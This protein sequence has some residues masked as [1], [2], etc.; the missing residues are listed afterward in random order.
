VVPAAAFALYVPRP[1]ANELNVLIASGVGAANIREIQ[2]P[3]GERISGWAFAH[4][5]VVLN[6]DAALE[7]GPVVKTFSTPLRYAL[8]VPIADG[9]TVVGVITLYGSE[10]F[11]KD[12]R[13]MLESAA[14]L[15]ISTVSGVPGEGPRQRH[16]L[17][18]PI[19]QLH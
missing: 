9:A 10:L 3:I 18:L 6:S 14:T 8:A 7:L 17:E 4:K 16:G 5:Q 11:D 15:F 2:I 12:H 19:P 13:R 1:D